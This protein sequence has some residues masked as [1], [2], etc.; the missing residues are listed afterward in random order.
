MDKLLLLFHRGDLTEISFSTNIHSIFFD[1]DICLGAFILVGVIVTLPTRLALGEHRASASHLHH[2]C[3]E[4]SFSDPHS[5][6]DILS[7][8]LVFC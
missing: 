8:M 5:L 4:V 3:S 6:H 7:D 1:V 2:M